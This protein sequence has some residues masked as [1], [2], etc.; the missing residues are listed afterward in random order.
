MQHTAPASIVID[1]KS[2]I[3]GAGRKPV[4]GS[5]Y[6]EVARDI[7]AYGLEGHR[8]QPEIERI[9]GQHDVHAPLV[10]T[11]HVVPLARGMLS[12]VYLTFAQA[13]DADV[14]R[15]LYGKA[16][17]GSP[18]VRMLDAETAPSVA[19]VIGTND[20]EIRVDVLGNTVRAICAID[21]LGRGAAGQAIAN[22]NV[23]LG[24]P[25]ET[26]LGN[27]AIVA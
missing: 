22:I 11:P 3:T 25:E 5:L 9:L 15:S 13:P 2:G 26:G 21:N 14:V 27:R 7:R 23:M 24:Y 17:A 18:F 10:F 6:T 4:L 19:A 16:Y 12:D 20:A 1:A 8:H